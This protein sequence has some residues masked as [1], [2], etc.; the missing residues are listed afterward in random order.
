MGVRERPEG[1]ERSLKSLR[2]KLGA[3]PRTFSPVS[4]GFSEVGVSG[5]APSTH[6]LTIFPLSSLQRMA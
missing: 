1:R 4:L 3:G 6:I 5:I 2:Q